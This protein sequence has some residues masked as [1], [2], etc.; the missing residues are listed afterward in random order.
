MNKIVIIGGG[1]A[2]I[3]AGIFAQKN[4]LDSIIL[5]KHHTVE[6]LIVL[7]MDLAS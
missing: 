1:I 2:G 5:E 4:G 7:A 3:T 6:C